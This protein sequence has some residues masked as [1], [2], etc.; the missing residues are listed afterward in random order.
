MGGVE[1]MDIWTFRKADN[2]KKKKK[3]NAIVLQISL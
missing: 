1:L 3:I 2:L